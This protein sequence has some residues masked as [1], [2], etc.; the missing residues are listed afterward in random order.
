L[1]EQ[2]LAQAQHKLGYIYD[3]GEGVLENDNTAVQ[4]HSQVAEQGN[5][6]AQYGLGLL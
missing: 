6:D 5:T 2:G 1:A 4:W 3:V